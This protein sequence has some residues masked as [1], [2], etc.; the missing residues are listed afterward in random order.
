ME[1]A[2]IAAAFLAT[3]CASQQQ[4]VDSM[5]PD[6]IHVAQAARSIRVELSRGDC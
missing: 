6:A 2:L 1:S 5:Q 4:Q 3:G